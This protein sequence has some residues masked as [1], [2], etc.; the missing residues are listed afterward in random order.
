HEAHGDGVLLRCR[1]CLDACFLAPADDEE[2]S[3]GASVLQGGHHQRLDEFVDQYLAGDGVRGLEDRREVEAF[4]RGAALS[5]MPDAREDELA[6]V[7]QDFGRHGSGLAPHG[8]AV[9]APDSDALQ[10]P[11]VSSVLSGAPT[12]RRTSVTNLVQSLICSKKSSNSGVQS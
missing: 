5:P 11:F 12:L 3:L 10:A 1:F 2:P 7:P 9:M 8:S 4:I 6:V